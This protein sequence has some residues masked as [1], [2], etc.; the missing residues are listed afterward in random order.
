V[1]TRKVTS[2]A[3]AGNTGIATEPGQTTR[4]TART[5]VFTTN[6]PSTLRVATA[7]ANRVVISANGILIA[8][9]T[10]IACDVADNCA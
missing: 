1:K 4:S 9:V 10:G 5:A 6:G 2:I 7:T 8:V 3:T